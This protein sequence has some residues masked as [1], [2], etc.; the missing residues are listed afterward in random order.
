MKYTYVCRP[1]QMQ[2]GRAR[3][4]S[5]TC[6]DTNTKHGL[7][8]WVSAMPWLKALEDEGIWRTVVLWVIYILGSWDWFCH[9][10]SFWWNSGWLRWTGRTTV[11]YVPSTAERSFLCNGVTSSCIMEGKLLSGYVRLGEYVPDHG[12]R[13]H[14]RKSA[15][16]SIPMILQSAMLSYLGRDITWFKKPLCVCWLLIAVISQGSSNNGVYSQYITHWLWKE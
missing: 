10:K 2:C 9:W 4:M 11:L 1:G 3:A 8:E 12:G 5:D 13:P 16:A 7:Q 14:A 15:R 6:G